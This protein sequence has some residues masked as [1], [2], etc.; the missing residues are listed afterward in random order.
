[1]EE[2][3]N[4]WTLDYAYIGFMATTKSGFSKLGLDLRIMGRS[5]KT[6]L[7]AKGL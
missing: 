4:E 2:G 6:L 3:P 7:E 1:V 5:L